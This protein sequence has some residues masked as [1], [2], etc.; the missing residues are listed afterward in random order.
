MYKGELI[1]KLCMG[2]TTPGV[3]HDAIHSDDIIA[4]SIIVY[5]SDWKEINFVV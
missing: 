5:F 2:R 4:M 1:L 3:F